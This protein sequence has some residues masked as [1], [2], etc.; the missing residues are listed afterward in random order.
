MHKEDWKKSEPNNNSI[1]LSI[2]FVS[3]NTKQ[4]VRA[5][6]PKK[7]N[8]KRN[9]QVILLIINDG[10]KWHCL[11]VKVLSALLQST[12]ETFIV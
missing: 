5:Y 12:M 6:P 9:N 4:I 10:K 2:L 7:H 8:H 3:C 11:A 1:A